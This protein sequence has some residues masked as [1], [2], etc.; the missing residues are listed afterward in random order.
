MKTYL[1]IYFGAVSAALVVTPLVIWF[2]HHIRIFDSRC[3]RKV[4]SGNV[5]RIGGLAIF[6]SSVGLL[7]SAA[8]LSNSVGDAFRSVQKQATVLL[9]GATL[10]FL[11]GF[12]DDIR[13]LR[14]GT[15][16]LGQVVAAVCVCIAG[17]RIESISL[18]D[19]FALDF[20]WFS[21]PLTVLWIVGITNAVNMSDG[22]DGLAAGISAVACGAI[23][24]FSFYYGQFLMAV[25]MLALLGSLTGFLF[26]N[27]NPAKV[28][29]GD[30]GSFFLGFIIAASSV[31][32]SVKST[33]LVALGLPALALGIPIFDTLFSM[34][35]RVLER[36]S[37]FAPDRSHFHHRLLH[38]GLKQRH[39]VITI[40][41]L[42]LLISG[43][44]LF[45]MVARRAESLVIFLC[46]LSLI[47]L[48]FRV[49]GSVRL[50]ETVAGIRNKYAITRQIKDEVGKFEEVQLHFR[51]AE[52]FQQ[53]W[54]AAVE[55]AGRMDF[56]SLHLLLTNRDGTPRAL[57]WQQGDNNADSDGLIK[58]HVPIQD[59][60]DGPHLDL[61]IEVCKNGSLESAGR[62]ITL[63]ARLMEEYGIEAL[64]RRAKATSSDA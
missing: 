5:P 18:T 59:R 34:L 51:Q 10:V 38:L 7:L 43:L 50:R 35:R 64:P 13:R 12:I 31:M 19:W 24:V 58:M 8:F 60:R 25:L 52:T 6:V 28:F 23:A 14:A 36:R 57:I 17:I 33:A 22:L 2:A 55:A 46:L 61:K 9:A 37:V 40:Y 39:V 30:G 62:R 11:V 16:L 45:M 44:A 3:V 56:S 21:W 20:G 41:A 4:H 15:K 53:W 29:L 49:V 47:L 1:F 54:Q 63:F 48:A 32:C 42:T 27:F 26:F